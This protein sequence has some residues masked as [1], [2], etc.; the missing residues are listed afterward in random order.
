MTKEEEYLEKKSILSKLIPERDEIQ[1]AQALK[2]NPDGFW[3]QS[4]KTSS[5][6]KRIMLVVHLMLMQRKMI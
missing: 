3:V 2:N 6:L 1:K 4:R 5:L